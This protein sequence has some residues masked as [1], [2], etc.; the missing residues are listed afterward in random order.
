MGGPAEYIIG[1]YHTVE[2][3]LEIWATVLSG[4]LFGPSSP[5]YLYSLRSYSLCFVSPPDLSYDCPVARP[6]PLWC[7]INF[8][9]WASNQEWSLSWLSWLTSRFTV[10]LRSTCL[11]TVFQCCPCQLGRSHLRSAGQWTML[12][13]RTKTVRLVLGQS[14]LWVFTARALAAGTPCLRLFVTSICHWRLSDVNWSFICL[15][16]FLIFVNPCIDCLCR[17]PFFALLHSATC[18]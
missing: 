9:G 18:A 13:P 3:P 2:T 7:M 11:P 1:V 10:W 17:L 15:A 6:F 14:A 8:T 16:Y 4:S 5:K 12:V